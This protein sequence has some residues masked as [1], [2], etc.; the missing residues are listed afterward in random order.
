[1]T[2]KKKSAGMYPNAHPTAPGGMS[3]KA[4]VKEL[5]EKHDYEQ[6]S[7][8]A[9]SWPEKID[10]VIEERKAVETALKRHAAAVKESKKFAGVVIVPDTD[11]GMGLLAEDPD[12]DIL[13]ELDELLEEPVEQVSADQVDVPADAPLF[14]GMP[15]T[16]DYIFDGHMGAS[17]S[18]A[19]RWISCTASLAASRA[20]LETLTPNQQA[21]FAGAGTAARQGTTA[22]AAAEAEA[23]VLIGQSTPEEA[24]ATL[25]ELAIMPDTDGEAYDDTMAEYIS[26]Y[27]DLIR[28]YVDDRGEDHVLIE[29]TVEA[30]VELMT[31]D[32]HGDP[33]I[34]TIRGSVD[35]GVL[36]TEEDPD[37]VAIDL[38]YGEGVDVDVD[39]NPQVRIYA[40]GLLEKVAEEHDGLPDWLTDVTYH[41]VQPRLGGI[42]TWT[43]SID[44]LLEWRDNVLGPALTEALG[45]QRS[46]A[47]FSPSEVACQWC[48]AR[49]SCPALAEQ[50][51]EAAAEL[52]DVIVEAEFADGPGAFPETESLSDE[53]LGA[54]YAQIKGLTDIVGDLKEEA[55]RRLY[56][57]REI[58][59]FQLVSYTPPRKWKDE[60]PDELNIGYGDDGSRLTVK[61]AE[62]LWREPTLVTPTQAQK[63][64]GDEGYAL[65]EDLVERPDKRPVIAPV[66]DRR[67]AWEGKPPEQMFDI[68]ED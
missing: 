2:T 5:V 13:A 14:I 56:R 27:T 35:C 36:P 3:E 38:K 19:E 20:F 21:A 16:K 53:R 26:E 49:G 62:L 64:L 43:E 48:P 42:K 37:L 23:L 47:K 68:E 4:L 65:I 25:V 67:K 39:E 33:N 32:E 46:G 29:Q 41:I 57:G 12:A 51:M 24:E 45:G 1:M 40:L 63:L 10:L 6:E 58:P 30:V 52:F 8:E 15:H 7:V 59:G 55:Q 44:D 50:R 17:P 9:L 34:H 18:G 66:G 54:L 31:V 28:T 60:A 61:Q 22:H 11:E